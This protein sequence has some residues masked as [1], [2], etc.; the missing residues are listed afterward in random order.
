MSE[1]TLVL[2]T[3]SYQKIGLLQSGSFGDVFACSFA[4]GGV[5][6][7]KSIHK[8]NVVELFD[9]YEKDLISFEIKLM[10]TISSD[11]KEFLLG[12]LDSFQTQDYV[13]VVMELALDGDLFGYC[14]TDAMVENPL[15]LKNAM[16]QM[17]ASVKQL[18]DMG[19]VHRYQYLT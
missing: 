7:V 4:S 5:V 17:V 11:G 16:V 3:P 18:H 12:C 14:S 2:E 13:H 19:I 9:C 1:E 10:M 6:A 15:L 8:A